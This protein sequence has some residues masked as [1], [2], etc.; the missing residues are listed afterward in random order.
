MG[1]GVGVEE[2]MGERDTGPCEARGKAGL[3][4]GGGRVSGAGKEQRVK[5]ATFAGVCVG[6]SAR[7]RVQTGEGGAGRAWDGGSPRVRNERGHLRLP[8]PRAAPSLKT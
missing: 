4:T 7:Q 5:K 6:V 8:L 2:R 3:R 1:K